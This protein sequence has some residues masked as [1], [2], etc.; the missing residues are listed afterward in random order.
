MFYYLALTLFVVL[1]AL[2]LW[3]TSR[4]PRG[5]AQEAN[6]LMR[7]LW[8][9]FGFKSLVIGKVVVTG[10]FVGYALVLGPSALTWGLLIV[11]LF[12][13][14]WVVGNNLM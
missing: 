7:R 4:F 11:V 1:Q 12:A 2:D 6:P 14:A 3:T 10:A 8:E 5:S 9:R 13:A